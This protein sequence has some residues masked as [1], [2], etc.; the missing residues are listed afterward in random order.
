MEHQERTITT[1]QKRIND[2]TETLSQAVAGRT[3]TPFPNQ[4]ETS[5]TEAVSKLEELFQTK[6]IEIRSVP[7]TQKIKSGYYSTYQPPV[8][9][10]EH[11]SKYFIL[12][13]EI[14]KFPNNENL[15]YS[16]DQIAYLIKELLVQ[17]EYNKNNPNRLI[18]LPN[19]YELANLILPT[20]PGAKYLSKEASNTSLTIPVSQ[21]SSA[22]PQPEIIP[23]FSLG[24]PIDLLK[25]HDTQDLT[26]KLS[27]FWSKLSPQ[28]IDLFQNNKDGALGLLTVILGIRPATISIDTAKFATPAIIE[29]TGLTFQNGV[30]FNEKAAKTILKES[31]IIINTENTD[32]LSYLFSPFAVDLNLSKAQIITRGVLL[33]YG[34][35]NA[36]AYA[37]YEIDSRNLSVKAGLDPGLQE[38]LKV[39]TILEKTNT[40]F[41]DKEFV[42][43]FFEKLENPREWEFVVENQQAVENILNKYLGKLQFSPESVKFLLTRR[44]VFCLGDTY[45]TAQPINEFKQMIKEIDNKLNSIGINRLLKQ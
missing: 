12:A 38:S 17:H 3:D 35:K 2:F 43:K 18:N 10:V 6:Q 16:N 33:G 36:Q 34:R 40:P 21:E 41:E 11:M 28:E 29:K 22:L 26:D 9:D 44:I 19:N 13:I 24:L 45:I 20:G 4:L 5:W 42:K 30:W 37:D 15:E 27:A 14:P 8:M 31:G 7:G 1:E 25:R 32:Q 39:I 23:S